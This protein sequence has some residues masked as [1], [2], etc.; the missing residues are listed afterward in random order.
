MMLSLLLTVLL[1]GPVQ[2]QIQKT[3]A[4]SAFSSAVRA[5]LSLE[6]AD[7]GFESRFF[8]SQR[9]SGPYEEVNCMPAA[10]AMLLRWAQAEAGDGWPGDGWPGDGWPGDGWPDART[11][12][13]LLPLRGAPWR[14]EQVREILE[15]AGLDVETPETSL[16]AMTEA[17]R[18]GRALLVLVQENGLGH[19][20]IVAAYAHAPGRK[21]VFE[22]VDPADGR[23]RTLDADALL[24]RMDGY[25]WRFLSVSR[26]PEARSPEG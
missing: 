21:T 12:R 4:P 3:P 15:R 1:L 6:G 25:W 23:A 26:S 17:L 5:V 9:G 11:L 7:V 22:I 19:C 8:V 20:Y 18:A 24:A 14:P 16:E 2:A 13:S 10:S